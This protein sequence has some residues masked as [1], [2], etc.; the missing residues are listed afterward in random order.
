M[1]RLILAASCALLCSCAFG[2]RPV[3]E[4]YVLKAQAHPAGHPLPVSLRVEEPEAGPGLD[5]ARIAVTDAPNHLTY[6]NGVAWAQPLPLMLQGFLVDAL[7]QSHAFKN[8]S[9]DAEGIDADMLLLTDIR[10]WQ[11]DKTTAA[12]GVKIRLVVKLVS[13]G[14]HRTIASWP[15]EKTVPAAAYHMPDLVAAFNAAMNEAAADIAQRARS[16]MARNKR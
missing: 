3:D 9:S 11:V 14:S 6:F 7:Q 4:L 15:I 8:I 5:T 16:V 2:S 1:N 10:D 13:A 12:P